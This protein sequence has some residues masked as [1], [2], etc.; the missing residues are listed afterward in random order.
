MRRA[1]C[2][3]LTAALCLSLA[4]CAGGTEWPAAGGQTA[5]PAPTPSP[6]PTDAAVFTDWSRL[7]TETAPQE[8][9]TRLS[10]G[11]M[12]TLQ[13]GDYGLLLPFP[14]EYRYAEGA[15]FGQMDSLWGLVTREGT[16]VLDPVCSNISLAG[17][18]SEAGGFAEGDVYV[19]RKLILDPSAPDA[20][21]W[22]RGWV[23]RCAACGL[24]GSWC[25]D[26][27]YEHVVGSPL[28]AL[29]I[30]SS[31][32]NLAECR[33]PSGEILFDTADWD[34]ARSV[35]G[36]WAVQS[37]NA[38]TPGGWAPVQMRGGRWFFLNARGETLPLREDLYIENAQ[39]FS[40]GLAAV[41]VDGLWG[42]LNEKGALAIAPQFAGVSSG[43]VGGYAIVYTGNYSR[44]AVIDR[45]GNVVLEDESIGREIRGGAG[46]YHCF[47][48]GGADRWYDADLQLV[49][50]ADRTPDG[51]WTELGWYVSG[52]DGIRVRTFEG[53]ERYY[54]GAED[55]SATDGMTVVYTEDAC[56]VYDRQN[57]RVVSSA[58]DN[59]PYILSDSVTGEDYIFVNRGGSGCDVYTAQGRFLLQVRDWRSP[60]DGLFL[61]SDNLTTGYRNP[62]GDWIFRIRVDQQD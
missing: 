60:A 50:V 20:D 9:Y 15:F 38:L 57:R 40:E 34:D 62:A 30:R 52:R 53:E 55:I 14:G 61:C 41:R 25:T 6:H 3:L 46:W 11:R 48:R 31:E 7:T 10:S 33:A 12:E 23:T 58:R 1:V 32:N 49:T 18:Y 26:F 2:A 54:P 8:K 29:C 44:S 19:L 28:G 51:C 21:E 13:P 39:P 47:S 42:F 22:N 27:V 17:W 37:L 5:A 16:V 24:D 43:F 45:R 56:T 35:M 59:W 4:A 36:A